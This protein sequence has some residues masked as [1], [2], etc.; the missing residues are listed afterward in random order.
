MASHTNSTALAVLLLQP[1]TFLSTSAA[2][3]RSNARM[4]LMPESLFLT[5]NLIDRFLA[6]KPVT[7][8]NLQLVRYIGAYACMP[9]QH[10]RLLCCLCRAVSRV[11]LLPSALSRKNAQTVQTEYSHMLLAHETTCKHEA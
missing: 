6:A 8:K 11:L 10:K 9:Q 5:V 2:A 4:Q 7:R 1:Q 3:I